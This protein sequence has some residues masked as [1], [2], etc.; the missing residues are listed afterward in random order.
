MI[1][2][3]ALFAVF[4]SFLLVRPSSAAAAPATV[5]DDHA[6]RLHWLGLKSVAADTNAAQFLKVWQLPQTTALV[7]QT[8][9][10]L[11]RW[12]GAGATNAAS[13]RLRPLLNDLITSEFYLEINAPTNSPFALR[14]SNFA[15]SLAVLLPPDRAALW[16][17]NLTATAS[18]RL[19]ISHAG[20]WTL[21]GFG[22]DQKI[23]KTAFAKHLP[24]HPASAATNLWLE[25]DF[26]PSIIFSSLSA[27]GE[28]RGEVGFFP[29]I[30]HH[31]S[32]IPD[33]SLVTRHSSP[34]DSEVGTNS[35][36][37]H[38]HLSFAGE[39][40][41]VVTRGT[42]DFSTPFA[43][44]LPAWEI[45]TN[46]IHG[47]LT[48][49]SAMRGIAPWLTASP[50]WQAIG[51]APAPDQAY[52]WSQTGVP[53]QT[54]FA[55]QL[56]AASNQLARLSDRLVANANPWLATNGQGSFAWQTNLPGIAWN[57]A[58]VISPV[59]KPSAAFGHDYVLG[60]LYPMSQ[61]DGDPF[62]G[63]YADAIHRRTNLVYFHDEMTG[64]RVED[65]FFI[66]Q[67]FRVVFKKVQLPGDSVATAWL[68]KAEPLLV[69]NTTF[70]SRT[71]P[72]QLGLESF[73]TIGLTALELHL[74]ADWLESPQFPRGLH[75]FL[76]QPD[77]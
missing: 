38:L 26:N 70:V 32:S 74:L 35:T 16:Q 46:L 67:L 44:P 47:P 9:D 69:R 39:S 23:A 19:E 43:A 65:N 77:K 20:D 6:F 52:V 11:S 56:P 37:N 76:A 28:G 71:G 51:L 17:S 30:I 45:P 34:P 8:L 5:S 55:A 62:P 22:L 40:G 21:V 64:Q 1:F 31:P 3:R 68:K 66:L 33:P 10:K 27:G 48:S 72:A 42:F 14:P 61:F 75:T 13:A 59:V 25:T 7:S 53:F 18:R 50:W 36:F 2:R 15:L 60:G 4:V 73:S 41:Y 57:D 12:P 24:R 63:E 54:Y 29:S 58:L 49:F